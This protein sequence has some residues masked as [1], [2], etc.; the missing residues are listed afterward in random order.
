MEIFQINKNYAVV[1]N[2]ENTRYGFRHLATLLKNGCEDSKAKACY[3]NRTW[4]KFEF[5]SV[6]L[7]SIRN[8][9]SLTDKEKRRFKNLVN[10]K[11]GY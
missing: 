8:S 3:Y 1:C 11:W 4:E 6:V 7:D 10:K 5:E 9:F 2:S